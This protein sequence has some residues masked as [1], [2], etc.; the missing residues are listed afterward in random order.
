VAGRRH[1]RGPAAFR[2][3]VADDHRLLLEALKGIL[4]PIAD[5]E[6]AGATT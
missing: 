1:P 2:I 5:L 4:E 3:V 6:L